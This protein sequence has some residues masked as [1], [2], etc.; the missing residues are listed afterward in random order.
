MALHF[1]RL[2]VSTC[3]LI[4]LHLPFNALVAS[5]CTLPARDELFALVFRSTTAA[6]RILYAAAGALDEVAIKAVTPTRLQA[7]PF[8]VA[9]Y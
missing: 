2:F 9:A 4:C 1:H 6:R 7:C 3:A 8:Q 5:F